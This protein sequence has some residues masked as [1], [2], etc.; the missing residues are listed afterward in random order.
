MSLQHVRSN[1]T[2]HKGGVNKRFSLWLTWTTSLLEDMAPKIQGPVVEEGD[3]NTNSFTASHSNLQYNSI[4][5]LSI[6]G[7]MSNPDAISESI[8]NFYSHLFEERRVGHAGW[9]R[10]F[11]IPAEDAIWLELFGEEEV[12]DVVAGFNGDKAPSDGFS[13]GFYQCCWDILR[14]D[15]M[16]FLTFSDLCSF[17]KFNA[18][19]CPSFRRRRKLWRLKVV[20]NNCLMPLFKVVRFLKC[21]CE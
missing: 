2:S 19:S 8:T 13:M 6:N 14:P 15:V 4:S 11:L 21:H 7:V 16:A 3:K 18:N 10:F 17:E 20:L 5:S 1:K 12:A 9:V